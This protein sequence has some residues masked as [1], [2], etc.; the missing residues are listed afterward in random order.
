MRWRL[1]N[2]AGR[3][4]EERW[5]TRPSA[6]GHSSYAVGCTIYA[7]PMVLGYFG[8]VPKRQEGGLILQPC[9]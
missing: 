3:S 2:L 5:T 8:T 1:G 7:L 6:S 4:L 9:L